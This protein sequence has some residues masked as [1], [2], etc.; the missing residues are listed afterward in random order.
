MNMPIRA[1][2]DVA[3]DRWHRFLDDLDACAGV[4]LSLI[5]I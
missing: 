1:R 2:H 4:P 3:M 5:H